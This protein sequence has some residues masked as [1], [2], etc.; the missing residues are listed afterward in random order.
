MNGWMDLYGVNLGSV[1]ESLELVSQST[2]AVEAGL[3]RPSSSPTTG[4]I[5]YDT[6]MESSTN[7]ELG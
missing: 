5:V 2:S 6:I 3:K 7:Q 1:S 4:N